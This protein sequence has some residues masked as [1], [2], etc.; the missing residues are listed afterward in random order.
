MEMNSK[1][2]LESLTSYTPHNHLISTNP[3]VSLRPWWRRSRMPTRKLMD[4]PMLKLEHYFSYKTPLSQQIFLLQLK[5]FMDDQH[6]EQSF[7]DPQNTSTYI[8]F[9]RDSSKFKTHRRN[10][11]TGHTEQRIYECSRW[12]RT[13]V[14]FQQTRDR[15]SDMADRNC[16]WNLGLW[17]F[18]HD[19]RPQW[20]SL[21]N[22]L[23]ILG[24]ISVYFRPWPGHYFIFVM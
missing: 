19:P 7:Q 20:Q 22:W 23:G 16:N 1:G 5:Y 2:L 8:R 9:G 17:S 6:K 14:L 15:P 13:T 11:L 3:M 18:I 24:Y 4:L 12:I 21:C 10:S